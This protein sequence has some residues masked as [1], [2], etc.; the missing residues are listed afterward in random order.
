M[1]YLL[2]ID[3]GTSATKAV[4]VG[5]DGLVRSEASVGYPL[6]QP[7][8]G[9]AEQDPERWWEAAAAAVRAALERAGVPAPEVAAIGL[10]GQMHGLVILDEA[11]RILRPAIL[12]C[13]QRTDAECAWLTRTVGLENLYRWTGNAAL[14]GFTAPKLLWLRRHE[15]EIYRRI[16]TVLLPKDYVRFRL[17]G[18]TAT[19]F[20]DASGT[21]LLDVAHRRWSDEM[22]GALDI[23]LQWL[24]RLH[25]SPQVTGV[26][27]AAAAEV[28]GVRAGTPVVAGAGDQAAGAVG[29]GAV[30]E[31]IFLA[32][33]GTSG[34]V[35]APTARPVVRTGSVLHAFCHAVPGR[36]HLMGV[37]LSAG[38]S[39]R[40]FRDQ[41]AAGEAARAGK[42]GIDPYDLLTAAAAAV[43]PGAQGLVF[44][45][46]LLG[47]RTPHPDPA[48]RG[49]FVGLTLRHTRAHM[50]RAVLEGIAFGLRDSLDLLGEAGAAP[51]EVRVSGGGAASGLW[52][53]ILADVFGCPVVYPHSSRGPAFGAALLAG[54]GAGMYVSVE[55]ACR[56]TVGAAGREEP[57]PAVSARYAACHALYRS[58]YPLLKDV[59]HQLNEL[60]EMK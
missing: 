26:V 18:E 49:A 13:D 9:W 28:T 14:P 58:L 30:E 46:Y 23:P 47:E 2:G 57:R 24:P 59:M 39:L 40:W 50:V 12:W 33:L 51:R 17:T 41:L 52:R 34:V 19:D 36:W 10:S 38:A 11:G 54:V 55:E 48:A 43:P 21:L 60:A 1:R 3:T 32:S 4:L 31:G 27:S 22:R 7:R 56:K 37:M 45:P 29:M 53:R 25:E 5:E 20:S 16:R 44:L 15:P 42:E 8:Q 35:F 6:D